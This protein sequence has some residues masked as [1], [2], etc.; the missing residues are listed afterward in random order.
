MVNLACLEACV[1]AR[2]S[3]T[4]MQSPSMAPKQSQNHNRSCLITQA[5]KTSTNPKS[6]MTNFQNHSNSKIEKNVLGQD[7]RSCCTSPMTGFYRDGFCR[8]GPDDHGVHT[9]CVILN[10]EFLVFS[11]GRGN[12][13]STPLPEYGFPGLKPG[14]KWCLCAG[15]WKEAYEDGFAPPIILESTHS[16]ILELVPL[17]VLKEFAFIEKN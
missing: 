2:S 3:Q 6:S 17:A 8:T 13:L 12:D 10:Q 14:D 4:K 9:V 16:S 5:N 15:R 7:L 11:K 1:V